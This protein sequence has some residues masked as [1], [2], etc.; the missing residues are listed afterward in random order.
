MC[1]TIIFVHGKD[2]KPEQKDLKELWFKA[3][4]LSLNRDYGIKAVESFDKAKK[5]FVYYGDISNDFLANKQEGRVNS[6]LNARKRCLEKLSSYSFQDFY[7]VDKYFEL[8]DYSETYD[9]IPLSYNRSSL[10]LDMKEYWNLDTYYG[11]DI[12]SKLLEPLKEALNSNDDIMLVTHSLGSIVAFDVL[13]KL[14]HYGEFRKEYGS[15]KKIS[16]W[17]TL[18]SELGNDKIKNNLKGATSMK[19]KKYPLNV[20]KWVDIAAKEGFATYGSNVKNNYGEMDYKYEL[21]DSIRCIDVYNL[22]TRNGKSNPHSSL[23]YLMHPEVSSQIDEW[24]KN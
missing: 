10:S 17:L 16:L 12:R 2:F 6:K 5:I 19:E 3:V 22:A 20:T 4:R 23:G 13:W 15:K 14:S 8:E 24:L 11:S 18:D 7:D 9:D 1:K 21:V